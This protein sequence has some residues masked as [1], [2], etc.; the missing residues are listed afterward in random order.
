MRKKFLQPFI[1]LQQIAQEI[2][3]QNL[4]WKILDTSF[5]ANK[6]LFDYQVEALEN[7]LKILWRIF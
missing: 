6:S 2:K 1:R 4:N 5:S 7:A 3:I